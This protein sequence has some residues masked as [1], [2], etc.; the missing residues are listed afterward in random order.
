VTN[1]IYENLQIHACFSLLIVT[2]RTWYLVRYLVRLRQ[3]SVPMASKK[4]SK[5]H[6][7]SPKGRP[8]CRLKLQVSRWWHDPSRHCLICC[9]I[10][11]PSRL[12]IILPS[13]RRRY[14]IG[15]QPSSKPSKTPSSTPSQAPSRERSSK[16][17]A[18]PSSTPSSDPPSVRTPHSHR[19]HHP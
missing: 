11:L 14:V 13:R 19:R 4:P 1:G 9:C 7:L 15:S 2:Y 17:S 10:I 16:P 8:L 5:N 6:L 12:S 3:P 18:A